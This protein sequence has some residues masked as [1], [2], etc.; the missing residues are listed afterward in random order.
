MANTR[1]SSSSSAA[2]VSSGAKKPSMGRSRKG[3]MKG[4]GGPENAL[5]TYRGVRQRTWGKWVA[6]IREP[7]RGTRLWLGTFN[8]SLEAA[9]A[10]DEAAKKLYGASA[11]LNLQHNHIHHHHHHHQNYFPTTFSNNGNIGS[12]SSSSAGSSTES[13]V[14][15]DQ[16]LMMMTTNMVGAVS[17]DE[18]TRVNCSADGFLFSSSVVGEDQNMYW[19]P[20]LA[21]ENDFLELT[22]IG[23]LMGGGGNDDHHDELKGWNIGLQYPWSL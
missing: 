8:T 22:D 1:R 16:D 10:Y 2:A 3:C 13:S 17:V 5:C 14:Q 9:T 20:E 12:D 21:V 19:V 4:K 7:N 18:H 23:V 6:E 15:G 11:K